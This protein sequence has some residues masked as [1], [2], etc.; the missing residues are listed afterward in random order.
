VPPTQAGTDGEYRKKP[1]V[2]LALQLDRDVAVPV[3]WQ[4]DPLR[5][6]PGDWLLRYEDGS[7]GVVRDAI[8]RETYGPADDTGA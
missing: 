3:G 1:S 7:L 4:D 6:R 8:F 5:G 2:T